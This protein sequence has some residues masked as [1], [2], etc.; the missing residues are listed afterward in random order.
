MT[1]QEVLKKRKHDECNRYPEGM[2]VF[3]G[4]VIRTNGYTYTVTTNKTLNGIRLPVGL[5]SIEEAYA[6]VMQRIDHY[7][8]ECNRVEAM[9]NISSSYIERH[10]TGME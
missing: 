1:D 8:K 3:G 10:G 9:S 5:L 4:I 2:Y 7:M 6:H